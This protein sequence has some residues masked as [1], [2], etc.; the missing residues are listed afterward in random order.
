MIAGI[1]FLWVW[2]SVVV[3]V[4]LPPVLMDLA[5]GK[6]GQIDKDKVYEPNPPPTNSVLMVLE[7]YDEKEGKN[8][9][10]EMTLELYGTVAPKTAANFRTL[11]RGVKLHYEGQPEGQAE[12]V[13]YKETLFHHIE[14]GKLVQGGDILQDHEPFSIYGDSWSAENFEL[15]HDRPGRLSMANN[16][17][18][19]QNSQFF[20]TTGLGGEPEFDER[21]TVFGQVVAGLDKLI[22][23]VQHAPLNKEGKPVHDI[24][25]KYILVW[26]LALMDNVAQHNVYLKKL[27]DFRNGDVSKGITMGLTFAEGQ[28][29]EK[30]LD[31]IMFNDLHHPLTKVLIAMFV[32][33]LVYFV[34]KS[35]RMS[36]IT[37][38]R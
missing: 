13:S 21:Y 8:V 38:R 11:A 4:A 37:R 22:S 17:P 28:Q 2:A 5:K 12:E 36:E 18:E 26:D 27:E 34:V 35:R 15:K 6:S 16:G 10:H 33:L 3:G 24:K 31:E 25:L 14:P 32:L 9:D 1:V 20:I 19:D 29:E 30:E 23:K 7:Y